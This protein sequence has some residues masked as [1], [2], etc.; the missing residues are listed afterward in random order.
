VPT[1][2]SRLQF[3]KCLNSHRVAMQLRMTVPSILRVLLLFCRVV[4]VDTLVWLVDCDSLYLLDQ[5]P[6]S[7]VGHLGK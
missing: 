1:V 6:L 3:N 7:H 5:K 4:S 2:V